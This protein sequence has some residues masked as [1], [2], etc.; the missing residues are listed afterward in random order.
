VVNIAYTLSNS[1]ARNSSGRY[2]L[3]VDWVGYLYLT[4][5]LLQI[6]LWVLQGLRRY[7]RVKQ[8]DDLEIIS[9]QI[10]IIPTRKFVML[11]FILVLIGSI[12]PVT[13]GVFPTRYKPLA[14]DEVP[15]ILKSWGVD[16]ALA[17]NLLADP[18]VTYVFGRELYPRF[19]R[20]DD[21]EMG[22]NWVAYAPLDFCRMGFV[23][24]GPAGI[25]Q[26]LVTLARPPQNF[27]N[28]SDTLA[29]GRVTTGY[30]RGK[31]VEYLH[32]DLIIQPG[33]PPVILEGLN[34]PPARCRLQ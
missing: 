11:G 4:A 23:M 10:T 5:G 32:A 17:K 14:R 12:I 16:P 18:A 8:D 1:L 9:T 28:R 7:T 26:V 30:V 19:Y 31:A 6:G 34:E 33:N 20:P 22:S 13:E 24:T 29:L 27:P 2:N 25:D 3:P 21:G 15:T